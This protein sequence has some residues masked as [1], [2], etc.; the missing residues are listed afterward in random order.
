[1][2]LL[3]KVFKFAKDL[4]IMFGIALLILIGI[5]L[6]LSFGFYFRSLWHSPDSNYKLKADTYAGASWAPQYYVEYEE[7]G[8]P[9]WKP[10]VYWGRRPHQGSVININAEGIRNTYQDAEMDASNS[11]KKVFMFGG[12]TM[13]GAAVRDDFTIPSFFAKEI[14]SKGVACKVTNYGQSGHVSTQEVIELLL[15]LQNGNIPDAVIFYDGVNDTFAAFQHNVAGTP[16]NE[17]NRE[18]EF[19]LL[20][21]KEIRRLAAQDLI[22]QLTLMRFLNGILDRSGSAKERS[23]L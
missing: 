7:L 22:K 13:W 15:Q 19:N 3:S 20:Q 10:Y 11:T 2:K 12:S 17:F 9:R 1:M 18:I 14:K 6:L 23:S 8:L 5:E 16:Q 21:K 4:W